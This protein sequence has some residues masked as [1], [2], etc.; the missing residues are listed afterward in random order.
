MKNRVF[1]GLCV[2]AMLLSGNVVFGRE[3]INDKMDYL[4]VA[5]MK[6]SGGWKISGDKNTI[7]PD[8]YVKIIMDNGGEKVCDYGVIKDFSSYAEGLVSIEFDFMQSDEKANCRIMDLRGYQESKNS[9]ARMVCFLDIS[10]GNVILRG[11]GHSTMG[12]GEVVIE[13]Y[14]PD[15]WYNIKAVVKTGDNTIAL[16]VNNELKAELASLQSFESI[17]SLKFA[18]NNATDKSQ[19]KANGA[20]ICIDNVFMSVGECSFADM[21]KISLQGTEEGV[22]KTGELAVSLDIANRERISEETFLLYSVL[23][24]NGVVQD[25]KKDEKSLSFGKEDVIKNVINVP[26]MSEED[27]YEVKNYLFYKPAD[28]E[29]F[30]ADAIVSVTE[31]GVTVSE[32]AFTNAEEKSKITDTKIEYKEESVVLSGSLG[33]GN[34]TVV[35][36]LYD[37][38]APGNIEFDG[39]RAIFV[40]KSKEDGSFEFQIPFGKGLSSGTYGVLLQG[41]NADMPVSDSFTFISTLEREGFMAEVVKLAEQGDKDALAEYIYLDNNRV[42]LESMNI[43]TDSLEDCD[44][45]KIAGYIISKLGEG[46]S[47]DIINEAIAFCVLAD[48]NENDIFFKLHKYG[49]YLGIVVDD[50]LFADEDMKKQLV[51]AFM[52][53]EYDFGKEESVYD[54][55][56]TTVSLIELNNSTF[57]KLEE[58]IEKYNNLFCIVLDDYNRLSGLKQSEV[59]KEFSKLSFTKIEKGSD[60]KTNI[61]EAF[62]EIV[63]DVRREK[64]SSGGKGSGGSGGGSGFGGGSVGSTTIVVKN[65]EPNSTKTEIKERP[66]KDIFEEH[67]A[68]DDIYYLYDNAIISGI[69]SETVAPDRAVKREEF[70]KMIIASFFEIDVTAE[71]VFN[72]VT[73]NDWF[74]PSVNTAAKLGLIYGDGGNFGTG[75]EITRQDAVVI[76]K[77]IVDIKGSLSSDGECIL[78]DMDDVSEYAKE[79]IRV[80][81]KA[82]V[83]SG[84][85]NRRV[86]P[87]M[88]IT[89]AEAARLIRGII[90]RVG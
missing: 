37:N 61:S 3:L 2:S 50:K 84:D 4:N 11:E 35:A 25:G 87:K 31:E 7:T 6:Q 78:S 69:D 9:N 45:E 60:G 34:K 21:K 53:Y 47:S 73:K 41:K 22:L 32:D 1:L 72:D 38:E 63:E 65:D 30:L 33:G 18:T 70:V 12:S 36:Y 10:E 83:V 27:I 14:S 39:V 54:Y 13:N 5:D 89:R 62:D 26:K 43:L 86:N 80:F 24:K 74:A 52:S 67:W 8:K 68:Y 15:E 23:L 40:A 58:V 17:S 77:R 57:D 42:L 66:F 81:A 90:Q 49:K 85:E 56:N 19:E 48:A 71:S 88:S 59:M 46:I 64:T 20:N 76:L 44:G 79:A 75:D 55:Y 51:Q 29:Y 28:G 82:G 16:Y